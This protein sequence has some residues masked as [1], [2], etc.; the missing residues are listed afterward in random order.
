M[1][2]VSNVD[3]KITWKGCHGKFLNTHF[4]H[5]RNSCSGVDTVIGVHHLIDKDMVKELIS[6]I[7]NRKALGPSRLVSDMVKSAIEA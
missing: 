7:K 5:D 1:L 4:A 6:K 2:T 3:K